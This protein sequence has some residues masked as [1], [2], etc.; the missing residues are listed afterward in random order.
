MV[1]KVRF[2]NESEY[3]TIFDFNPE[4]FRGDINTENEVFGWYGDVYVSVLK[5]KKFRFN[6]P[7]H[8][9]NYVGQYVK[10]FYRPFVKDGMHKIKDFK[11]N[12]CGTPL[13]LYDGPDGEWWADCEDS[14]IITNETPIQNIDWVA[15]INDERYKGYNPFTDLEV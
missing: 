10:R 11:L 5:D 15:N 14:C 9:K 3:D 7:Q 6:W 8:Y 1:K 13:Y 4:K 12:E 2:P